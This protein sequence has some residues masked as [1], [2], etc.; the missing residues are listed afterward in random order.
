MKKISAILM[1]CF[2]SCAAS[3]KAPLEQVFTCKSGDSK[4]I[5]ELFI[6][7]QVYCLEELSHPAVLMRQ[8]EHG[9]LLYHGKIFRNRNDN[10]EIFRY[11]HL[12]DGLPFKVQ[13][14]FPFEIGKGTYTSSYDEVIELNEELAC[15]MRQIHVECE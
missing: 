4:I 9:S 5:V 3:A 13:M 10:T 7:P 12:I 6:D 8:S 11:R 2:L 14:R 1:I 15:V